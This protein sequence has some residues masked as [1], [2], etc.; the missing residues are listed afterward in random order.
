MNNKFTVL[1]DDLA[2][3]TQIAELLNTHNNLRIK[4]T[5]LSIL[6]TNTHY[7][8]EQSIVDEKI[9]V[10]GCVGLEYTDQ[11]MTLIKHLCVHP[12]MRRQGIAFKLLNSA[13]ASINTTF[14][15]MNIR[16]T[17]YPSLSLA[18]KAKFLIVTYKHE[19][20][21]YLITVGRKINGK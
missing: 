11:D 13:I 12:K 2:V 16:S 5:G 4:H 19:H 14:A 21:Y 7:L 20:E 17:N 3:A 15:H 1:V 6:A 10:V 18:E 9:S 8:I